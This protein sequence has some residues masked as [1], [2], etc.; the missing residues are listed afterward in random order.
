MA[1]V[2]YDGHSVLANSKMMEKFPKK[3]RESRGFNEETGLLIS[4]L[5]I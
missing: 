3:V 4:E 5:S 2:C 1:V